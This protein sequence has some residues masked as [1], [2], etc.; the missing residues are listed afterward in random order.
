MA[1]YVTIQD[2]DG[3]NVE[4]E[5]TFEVWGVFE[6]ERLFQEHVRNQYRRHGI[7]QTVQE[8]ENYIGSVSTEEQFIQKE[9]LYSIFKILQ[10]CTP[11]R[12]ERFY[13]N[14]VEGYR[15]SE[16]AKM[17][18]CTEQAIQQSIISVLKKLKKFFKDAFKFTVFVTYIV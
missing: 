8:L 3:K 4:V 2:Y 7:E 12:H 6:Q 16:I 17:Q 10:T 5:V 18:G 9:L 1:Y 11:I 14:R 13:L 15:F